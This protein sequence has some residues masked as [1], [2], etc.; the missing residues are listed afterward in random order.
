MCALHRTASERTTHFTIAALSPLLVPLL[1]S[2]TMACTSFTHV[3]Q[4]ILSWFSS[5]RTMKKHSLHAVHCLHTTLFALPSHLLV[6]RIPALLS[7]VMSSQTQGPAG[8]CQQT[9][10]LRSSCMRRLW[11]TTS[12]DAECASG[13]PSAA[14]LGWHSGRILPESLQSASLPQPHLAEVCMPCI[15]S[16]ADGERWCRRGRAHHPR[17]LPLQEECSG[18]RCHRTGLHAM[19]PPNALHVSILPKP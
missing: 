1:H 15:L 4:T 14:P 6:P 3:L 2:Y 12:H 5:C 17:L 11:L 10:G 9:F 16:A 13:W 8:I 7:H 18:W 19:R